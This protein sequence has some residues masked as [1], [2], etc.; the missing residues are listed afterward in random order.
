MVTITAA[1]AKELAGDYYGLAVLIA[2]IIVI[3]GYNYSKKRRAKKE[4]Q[5]QPLDESYIDT[6]SFDADLFED[7]PARDTLSSL[8]KQKTNAERNLVLIK[9]DA[10]KIVATEKQVDYEYM[11]SKVQFKNEKKRLGLNYTNYM[12]Q[13]RILDEMIQNQLKMQEDSKKHAN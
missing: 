8:K 9:R 5:E 2:I 3:L 6:Q 4:A 10:K 13:S 11:Q 7:A 1:G 12:H